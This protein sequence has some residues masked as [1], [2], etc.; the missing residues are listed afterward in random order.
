MATEE[1]QHTSSRVTYRVVAPM[2][3]GGP[4]AQPVLPDDWRVQ[5]DL[6]HTLCERA[7]RQTAGLALEPRVQLQAVEGEYESEEIPACKHGRD[8][9]VYRV[10][11]ADD[12][13]HLKWDNS[14]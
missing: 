2:D 8:C 4:L 10:C 11:R 13:L 7:R 12:S 14:G 6:D 1:I 3:R 9:H 5:T